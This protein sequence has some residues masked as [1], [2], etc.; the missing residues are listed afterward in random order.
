MDEAGCGPWAG[1]VVAAAVILRRHR[2]LVRVD[3]SKRLTPLQRERAYGA[4]LEH[5][6]VGFG[7]ADAAEIDLHNILQ[8]RLLAMQRALGDL[9]AAAELVLVDGTAAPAVEAACWAIVDGDRRSYVIGCASIMAKVARD[10]M[11]RFYHR[12]APRYG[13]HRHKGYGTPL[14]I[15]RL[16]RHGP[17]LFHRHTFRPVYEALRAV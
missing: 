12:L 5:A 10:R 15:A 1:P 4:I 17:C 7:V 13:F 6:E 11:M 3:D 14:H 8:A 9:P 16:K 2:L